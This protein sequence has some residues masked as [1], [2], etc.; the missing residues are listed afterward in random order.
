MK[1][2]NIQPRLGEELREARGIEGISQRQAA[3]E[4]HIT[5]AYLCMLEHGSKVPSLE[6]LAW[7]AQL[8]HTTITELTGY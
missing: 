2:P 6:L 1:T 4:A 7:L 3:Q 8:Y 5:P